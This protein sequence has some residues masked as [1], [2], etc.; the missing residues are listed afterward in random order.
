MGVVVMGGGGG[1]HAPPLE[2]MKELPSPLGALRGDDGDGVIY[3]VTETNDTS[4]DI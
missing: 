4:R 2:W 3:G 1:G